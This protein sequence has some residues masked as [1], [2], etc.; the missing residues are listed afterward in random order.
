MVIWAPRAITDIKEA[1]DF[2]A[3]D[4][5]PAANRVTAAIQ[6]TGDSLDQFPNRG[7]R[8]RKP[9]TREMVVLRT[10]YILIYHIHRTGV[11]IARV[12]HGAQDWPP[13]G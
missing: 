5:E 1:W 6:L 8:G 13:K 11:E 2:I 3:I 7:R 10:P 12:I 4:N 9:G